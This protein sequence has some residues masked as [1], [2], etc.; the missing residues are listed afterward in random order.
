VKFIS[1]QQR[2]CYPGSCDELWLS[3]RTSGQEEMHRQKIHQSVSAE[4]SKKMNTTEHPQKS[5]F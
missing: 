4:V 2:D 1:S 5:F 3:F